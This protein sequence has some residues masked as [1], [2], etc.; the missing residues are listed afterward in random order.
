MP[1]FRSMILLP[2]CCRYAADA[3]LCFF[4][5]PSM[6]RHA[7]RYAFTL[8][9]SRRSLS[10]S[11]IYHFDADYAITFSLITPPPYAMLDYAAL[12]L[13][14]A[15]LL[16]F[17]YATRGARARENIMRDIRCAM[18]K[19][20]RARS[21]AHYERRRAAR[22][23]IARAAPRAYA[24]VDNG[25]CAKRGYASASAR[26]AYST[27]V[28]VDKMQNLLFT[29]AA[30]SRQDAARLHRRWRV[31]RRFQAARHVC[32]AVVATLFRRYCHHAADD[33]IVTPARR[34]HR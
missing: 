17:D 2:R 12:P 16:D 19:I 33:L 24:R 14:D 22:M 26:A 15:M 29:E 18:P 23:I 11:M 13:D 8:R 4:A 25:R 9:L 27:R 10:I 31:C 3:M 28:C 21:A 20:I 34:C 5:S 32:A 7:F 6:P 30:M 1:P